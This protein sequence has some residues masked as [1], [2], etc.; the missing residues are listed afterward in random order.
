[1][2]LFWDGG[3]VPAAVSDDENNVVAVGGGAIVFGS[4]LDDNRVV[5][6]KASVEHGNH[7]E[8]VDEQQTTNKRVKRAPLD[9]Y[10]VVLSSNNFIVGCF[11]VSGGIVKTIDSIPMTICFN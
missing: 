7:H 1:M 9:R 6:A 2:D 10:I 8:V 3:E 4:G 11:L 5:M